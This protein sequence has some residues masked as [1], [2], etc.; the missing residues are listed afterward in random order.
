MASLFL[1]KFIYKQIVRD[2]VSLG[3]LYAF[4]QSPALRSLFSFIC[5]LYAFYR[6]PIYFYLFPFVWVDV[7][8]CYCALV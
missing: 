1:S 5:V 6:F 7:Y 3:P 8:A 4:T 2:G